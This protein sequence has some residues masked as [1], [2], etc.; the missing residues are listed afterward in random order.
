MFKKIDA[1]RLDVCIAYAC[2][3]FLLY[4]VG[5]FAYQIGKD[6]GK[7]EVG[8]KIHEIYTRGGHIEIH[9]EES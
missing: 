6:H 2:G 5:A 1:T 3:T 7:A 4:V 9:E 8:E